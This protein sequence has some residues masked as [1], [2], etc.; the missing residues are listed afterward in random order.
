MTINTEIL[1]NDFL[2]AMSLFHEAQA[3]VSRLRGL[4][5]DA[6]KFFDFVDEWADM[7]HIEGYTLFVD[8]LAK[9]L[10]DG[11]S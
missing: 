10:K 5:R 9:E 4:L 7:E 8:E 6:K 2:Q 11:N 1:V 3:D